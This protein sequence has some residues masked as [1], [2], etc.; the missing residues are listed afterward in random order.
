[1]LSLKKYFCGASTKKEKKNKEYSDETVLK[2][3]VHLCFS[4]EAH[5]EIGGFTS[6]VNSRLTPKRLLKRL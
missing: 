6:N 3:F 4:E 1:M 2:Q 5:C